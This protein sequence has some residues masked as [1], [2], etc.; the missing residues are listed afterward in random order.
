[1]GKE[2]ERGIRRGPLFRA[3][4]FFE[5]MLDILLFCGIMKLLHKL[6]IGIG[7][8]FVFTGAE[9]PF[10]TITILDFGKSAGFSKWLWEIPQFQLGLCSDKRSLR[11]SE[12]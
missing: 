10:L 4:N 6:N 7:G 1:M 2:K 12:R 8:I 5:K 9:Y 11:F 3:S